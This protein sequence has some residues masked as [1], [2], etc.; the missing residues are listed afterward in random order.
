MIGIAATWTDGSY[1]FEPQCEVEWDATFGGVP[2]EALLPG[3]EAPRCVPR[4]H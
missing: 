1:E 4:G 3:I 2:I